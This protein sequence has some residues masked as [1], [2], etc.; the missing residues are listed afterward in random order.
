MSRPLQQLRY[1]RIRAEQRRVPHVHPEGVKKT[2]LEDFVVPRIKGCPIP[3]D[4]LWYLVDKRTSCGFPYRKPH[5][6]T[7]AGVAY[8]KSGS[9][10]FLARC[11]RRRR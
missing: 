9:R 8:R 3:T 10:S 1:T 7:M 5:I 11:G 2:S 4:F 6:A